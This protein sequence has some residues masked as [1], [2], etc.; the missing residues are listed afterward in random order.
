LFN[1]IGEEEFIDYLQK[2]YPNEFRT[3]E[4]VKHMVL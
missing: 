2:R 1:Y 3:M 4:Y